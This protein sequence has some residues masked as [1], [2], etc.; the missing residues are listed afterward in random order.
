V[1]YG[2]ADSASQMSIPNLNLNELA[3]EDLKEAEARQI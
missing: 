2:R 3:D 1:S